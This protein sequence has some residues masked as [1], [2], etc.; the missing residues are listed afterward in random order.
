LRPFLALAILVAAVSRAGAAD[1]KPVPTRRFEI[2]DDRPYLG[3]ER[4][5]LWGI[6][7]GNA[8]MDDAVTERHVRC[9]DN[10]VAHGVNC[11]GCYL[12]GSNG[13]WPDPSA[14]KNGFTPE[15]A[16]KPDFARRLEWLVREADRRGMVVMVGVLSPRKDTELKDEAAVRRAIEETGKLLTTRGLRNVF[17]DLC[18]EYNSTRIT[19]RL[20]HD[21][22]HE[23]DGAAKKAKLTAWFKKYAPDVPAGVCPSFPTNT[24]DS[25]PGMD[26]RIIQK[27]AAIPDSGF[28][29]NVETT[30]E[31]IYDNDGIF[32]PE[33]RARM[34]GVWEAYRARPNA[35]LLF[36]SAF[37]QGVTNKSGTAPHPEMGGN[38]TGPDDR[39]VRFYFEWVRDNIG[40][41]QYPHHAK[42]R[43]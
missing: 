29:V 31:D 21:I 23:P 12:Q 3:G 43:M 28:V 22:L 35:F 8:L 20:D 33:A 2:R 27:G 34:K 36:H 14:G 4:I 5:D 32:T 17:V 16:L 38:G 26:V 18:H 30:R 15:G 40:P 39:G 42:G 13:G 1:D 10:L 19:T 9:L 11:I 7:C 6:R 24:A 25:Y 41:Y 37:T